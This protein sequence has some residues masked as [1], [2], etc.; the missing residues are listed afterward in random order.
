MRL[1]GKKRRK[2]YLEQASGEYSVVLCGDWWQVVCTTG[3]LR[4]GCDQQRSVITWTKIT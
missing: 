1:A 3:W 2:I 4:G